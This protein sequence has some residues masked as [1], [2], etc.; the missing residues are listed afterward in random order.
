MYRQATFGMARAPLMRAAMLFVH[1]SQVTIRTT[2]FPATRRVNG[3]RIAKE[4]SAAR[5]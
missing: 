4:T 3:E 2:N 5:S 1:A